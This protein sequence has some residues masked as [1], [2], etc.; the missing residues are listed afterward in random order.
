MAKLKQGISDFALS[1]QLSGFVIKDGYQIKYL[2]IVVAEREYWIKLPKEM[3][4]TFNPEI[5]PGCW[6][7]VIGIRKQSKTGKLKLEA[8]EVRLADSSVSKLDFNGSLAQRRRGAEEKRGENLSLSRFS[9]GSQ[10]AQTRIF[11]CRKSSCQ[12]KGG[13]AICQAIEESL[14]THQLE[15]EVEVKL[16]G[17]LKQCKHG[18]NLIIMPDK[19]RYGRVKPEQIPELLARHL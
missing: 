19:A 8:T 18:P 2:R 5:I 10:V 13:R 6:L 1:G 17:C 16:T 3:R 11:V 9:R 15:E 12:K 14:R 4:H 7:D